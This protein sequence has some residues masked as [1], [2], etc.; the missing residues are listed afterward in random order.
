MNEIALKM[1]IYGVLTVLIA[2]V[3]METADCHE[4]TR[5]LY[6]KGNSAA[7]QTARFYF[8]TLMGL[9]IIIVQ[10][11]FI[12]LALARK[13]QDSSAPASAPEGRGEE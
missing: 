11:V 12:R 6:D 2:M 7:G 9:A 10:N 3:A 5:I 8:L 13:E 4:A 1:V